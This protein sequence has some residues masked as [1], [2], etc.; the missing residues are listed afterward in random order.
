VTSPLRVQ[1]DFIIIGAH[2]SGTTSLYN[3]LIQHPGVM[4]ALRKEVHFFDKFYWRRGLW[5]RACFPTVWEK[6]RRSRQLGYTCRTGEATPYY[7]YHPDI[8]R[9]VKRHVPQARLIVVLRD[10]VERAF[11]HYRVNV[12]TG[13][14]TVSFE[15]AL[16]REEDRLRGETEKLQRNP[17]YYSPAHMRYS[18][19]GRGV[20]VDQL[21]NWLRF[22]PRE[23]MLI[24]NSQG[25]RND[26]SNTFLKTLDFVG[27]PAWEPAEY[28][29]YLVS[30]KDLE[31]SDATRQR[32]IAYFRPHNQ[33]LYDYLG[34][35]FGWAR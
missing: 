7:L 10:P 14:E 5:Y 23:Q 3:Y 1:P 11:S 15:E 31:L 19:L 9:R 24:L 35:D 20:Y 17:Y 32:L 8:P 33:R 29:T 16:D 2:K 18:Y 12:K 34:L 25:L 21:Q 26:T 6:A 4:A 22:F 27:L 30:P 28:K 13:R